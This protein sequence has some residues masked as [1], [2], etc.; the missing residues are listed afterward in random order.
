MTRFYLAHRLIPWMGTPLKLVILAV[1]SVLGLATPCSADGTG[2]GFFITADG[3]LLTNH[4]V[5]DG[6]K[7]VYVRHGEKV[8]SAKVVKVS[9]ENDIAVL[10]L[11]SEAPE[12]K[13]LSLSRDTSTVRRLDRVFTFGFPDPETLGVNP[14]ATDGTINALSG[15]KDDRTY[16][17]MSVPIQP[18]NSG[19]PLIDLEGNV[20]GLTTATI[21]ALNR[22]EEKKYVPQNVNY[23]VKIEHA[24][25]LLGD[26]ITLPEPMSGKREIGEIADSTAGSIA[27]II[28]ISEP[29]PAEENSKEN[30]D[31]RTVGEP[32][33]ETEEGKAEGG[34]WLVPDSDKRFL[35]D[36]ELSGAHPELLWHA[37]N[38]IFAR[39]GY[40]F[41]TPRGKALEAYLGDEYQPQTGDMDEIYKKFNRFERYNVS[42]LQ[43]FEEAAKARDSTQGGEGG[44]EEVTSWM[45]PDSARRKLT[46]ADLG[47]LS[48]GQLWVARNEIYARHGYIFSSKKG[49]DYTRSL[50]SAYQGV[51]SDASAVES[52]FNPVERANIALIRTYE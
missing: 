25:E 23:S 5:I 32:P 49:K 41:S 7:E 33:A 43:L 39:H 31:T 45:F 16:F 27:L 13:P 19:G 4:H 35:K 36:E 14:K 42:R 38:E 44:G 2:T 51:T 46:D 34:K 37:R 26:G 11:T 21:N 8:Y 47:G 22:I 29:A 28:A 9:K 15:I 52:K 12:M 40:I 20:I 10:Q 17:Q 3:L 18:G 1:V 50:G 6:A 30:G 24:L 48:K